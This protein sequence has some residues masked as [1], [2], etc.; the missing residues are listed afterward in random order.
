[1]S[2]TKSFYD[3]I[4]KH[5]IEIPIIQREYA[6]GRTTEKV[7]SIRKRFVTDLVKA[8]TEKSELHLGFVYGKIVGKENLQR[9]ILN[10]EAVHSILEA[11]KFYANNLELKINANIEDEETEIVSQNFL[12][13]IPLDGQ[14]RL[15]TLYILHWY[16]LFKGAKS[17]KTEWLHHFKYTNRKSAL[18]FCNELVN[19]ENIQTLKQK[20]KTNPKTNIRELITNSGF[21]LKK[22]NKD[23]TVSGILEMLHS[24]E[25]AFGKDYDFSNACLEHLPLR[26]DFMDLDSLNQ[27]D[28][29]YV[30]MNSRGKQLSDYEHFKSWLQEKYN[31]YSEQNWFQSFWKKLDTDW[32]NYF[33][34]NIDADF[35][36][37]DYFYY[38]Y[39]KNLALMH[40]LANNKEIPFDKLKGIY[41]QIRNTE[42]YDN[43]KI[44][45]IPLE[46]YFIKWEN[47]GKEETFFIFNPEALRFIENTLDSLL[48][49]EKEQNIEIVDLKDI[50]CKPFTEHP[51]THFFLKSSLFT[52]SL[53][54][55]VFY[56]SFLIF[57]ND[58]NNENYSI[59]SMKEWLR[60]TRNT[61]Y[62]TYIQSPENFNNALKQINNLA[63]FKFNISEAIL[64]NDVDNLFFENNQFEEEK[65]KLHLL[66][67]DDWKEPIFR[68]ENHS[69]LY[70]QIR[71]ILEFS[72]DQSQNYVL[73]DF[74]KYSN[75]AALLY[76]KEIRLT[77]EKILER[78]LF[79]ED[80]YLPYYKSDYIFCNGSSGGLRTKNENWRLFF[81]GDKIEKLKHAIDRLETKKITPESLSGY[82]DNYIKTTN[83]NHS[84]WKYLFLKYP[85]T[86]NY[87]KDS[88]IRWYSDNDIRLLKGFT[89]TAYHSELRTYCFFL[90][91][92]NVNATHDN[93][94]A[95][96]KFLPFSKF[97]YF[98][99]KNTDGHPGCYLEGLL[100]N[101]KEYK[102]DIR[103]SKNKVEYELCFYHKADEME[104][105]ISDID[106][107]HLNFSFDENYRHYFKAIP[108]DELENELV[109][110][111]VEL[112]KL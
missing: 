55:A 68:T 79:C 5:I 91:N 95:P 85:Q 44:S 69:Y 108:Y 8:I 97:W 61:I 71:F 88:A 107:E 81:K 74:I 18:A 80:F 87:C 66:Q 15:T 112:K 43:Q 52:P 96:D 35:N 37:L 63:A 6:Q 7:N 98:E 36:A 30:K 94:I 105:R 17:D 56:Y 58:R 101:N 1:M 106:L 28:E 41:G 64:N 49:L 76:K 27:T 89:I 83:L 48:Y 93:R 100:Y 77:S 82:I 22:W 42:V 53:W 20:Q 51:I 10:K 60:Y 45:Y 92:K 12:K 40:C 29:L 21:Y 46:N 104:N 2:H 54:N 111:C 70:G 47:E 86:I 102:L 103:Y 73:E 11:V 4:S 3:I 78:F 14:Q 24:L 109:K 25:T 19:L 67:N 110:L 75:A 50:I 72:K 34:R 31:D 13:F 38:N 57:I 90:E 16:L 23:A 99:E 9:K 65:I 26:F 33:W 59:Q 39:I 84:D 62:N 32:L